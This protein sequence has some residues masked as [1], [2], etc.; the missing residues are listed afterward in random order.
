MDDNKK[1]IEFIDENVLKKS[2]SVEQFLRGLDI[3]RDYLSLKGPINSAMIEYFDA[4]R[5]SANEILAIKK[6]GVCISTSSF[7]PSNKKTKEKSVEKDSHY[8]V[9]CTADE[10]ASTLSHH[11][12]NGC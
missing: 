8:T 5:K 12:S 10:P 6:K 3:T 7:F 4:L 1:I 11:Y 2:D 9:G